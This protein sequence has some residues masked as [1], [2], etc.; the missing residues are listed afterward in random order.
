MAEDN[1]MPAK[2]K[3]LMVSLYDMSLKSRTETSANWWQEM[4]GGCHH[5]HTYFS[6]SALTLC[7]KASNQRLKNPLISIIIIRGLD[8]SP[9][10]RLFVRASIYC[11]SENSKSEQYPIIQDTNRS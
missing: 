5:Q 10:V 7:R 11:K 1:R 9:M 4:E 3:G 2:K 6:T 8:E